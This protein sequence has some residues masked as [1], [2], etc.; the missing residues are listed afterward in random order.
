MPVSRMLAQERRDR[1]ARR[2]T[3][4]VRPTAAAFGS[5]PT[6]LQSG[7]AALAVAV[8]HRRS[9]TAIAFTLAA[10]LSLATA[11]PVDATSAASTPA[12]R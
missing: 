1:V 10:G 9:I 4:A 5:A 7:R 12:A 8:G 11:S 2:A 6:T 3:P